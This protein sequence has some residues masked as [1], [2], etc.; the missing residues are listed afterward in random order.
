MWNS[1]AIVFDLDDTLYLESIYFSEIFSKFCLKFGWSKDTYKSLID[2]FSYIR[3][4]KKNIFKFF[5]VENKININNEKYKYFH[6]YLYSLYIN[7]DV[8]LPLFCGVEESIGHIINSGIKVGV[9][10][11]GVVEAQIN[12]WDNLSIKN[13]KDIIFLPARS[14]SNEKPN[15]YAFNAMSEFLRV[16]IGQTIYVGDNYKNDIEYPLTMGAK[17][18]FI[19]GLL[20]KIPP[21]KNLYIYENIIDA[22][23]VIN[24]KINK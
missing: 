4:K 2:N 9:L 22:L 13:K 18:I 16:P 7:L 12:K 23:I 8:K 20:E 15:P 24:K 21:H 10:T 19:S 11:N 5:L 6:N 1:K 17:C 14:I 3:H